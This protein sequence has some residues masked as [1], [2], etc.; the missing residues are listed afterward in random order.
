MSIIKELSI[1]GKKSEEYIKKYLLMNASKDFKE[2][3]LYQINTGGK[4]IRPALTLASTLACEGNVNTALPAAASVEIVHNYSLILDDIIDHS[5]LR[6]GKPTVWKKYGTSTAILI[7][8]HY[9]ESATDALND[10]PDPKIFNKIFSKSLKLLTD[11]ERLDILF[12]QA[13]RVDEPYVLE[14][15]YKDVTF[16][17]YLDMIYKKTGALIETSC[18]FG[19]LSA[20]ASREF[21]DALSEYGR[22]LGYAFQIGDDIIDLFG[23]TE[24]TGKKIGGDITEHKFGNAVIALALQELETEKKEKLLSIL[25][26]EYI[27]E[28]DVREAIRIIEKYSEARKKAEELREKYSQLAINSI[29]ILSSNKGKEY[30]IDL[31]RF[32]SQRKY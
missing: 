12:E 5:E 25:R 16:E 20:G 2:A 26:Q 32:I 8:V 3:I 30:L 6:R 11:G 29:R 14:N 17:D 15:R 18:I 10:T 27:T 31:A 19:G 1:L 28:K 24:E 7:A 13:G 9:R 23:K 21:L 4:R 22:M